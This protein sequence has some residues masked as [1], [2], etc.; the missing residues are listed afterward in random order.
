MRTTSMQAMF[1]QRRARFDAAL[2]GSAPVPA[3][4][5][6][7]VAGPVCFA[8]GGNPLRLGLGA[9]GASLSSALT[10]DDDGAVA[11][12]EGG[13]FTRGFAVFGRLEEAG[14]ASCDEVEGAAVEDSDNWCNRD[15]NAIGN[16][17]PALRCAIA[18]TSDAL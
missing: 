2:R 1:A 4:R 15:A 18:I 13:A 12:S 9:V 3:E 6:D 8:F 10:R 14:D 11:T 16:S 5:F 7:G 17:K